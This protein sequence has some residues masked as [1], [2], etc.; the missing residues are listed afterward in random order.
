MSI[1]NVQAQ[2]AAFYGKD[3]PSPSQNVNPATPDN[4]RGN[5]EKTGP[6]DIGKTPAASPAR[7][8]E[9]S[10]SGGSIVDGV[11]N[12]V[13]DSFNDIKNDPLGFLASRTGPGYLYGLGKKMAHDLQGKDTD[14]P[15]L[16]ALGELPIA[17]I[18]PNVVRS[19]LS[20][21]NGNTKEAKE[22]GIDAGL[23]AAGVAA[24]PVLGKVAKGVGKGISSALKGLE[25]E[26]H[27]K[28]PQFVNGKPGYLAGP[29]T[30]EAKAVGNAYAV[31]STSKT[32]AARSEPSGQLSSKGEGVTQS[33]VAKAEKTLQI[34]SKNLLNRSSNP[35]MTMRED[36]IPSLQNEDSKPVM[37]LIDMQKLQGGKFSNPFN[38]RSNI[39]T[40]T[41]TES[42]QLA[43]LDFAEKNRIPVVD[44]NYIGRDAAR[45]KTI[46]ELA[47]ETR[48]Y[49]PLRKRIEGLESENFRM[50]KDQDS[51]VN[52][53]VKLSPDEKRKLGGDKLLDWSDF[54]KKFPKERPIILMG[55]A[56]GVCVKA[57]AADLLAK[58][59]TVLVSQDLV[60][61]L[62][63]KNELSGVTTGA[64]N[65]SW[66]YLLKNEHPGTLKIYAKE[67][68][69]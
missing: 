42:N 39:R 60:V 36:L 51:L 4:N 10:R 58:G 2:N 64:S 55:Q 56:E 34:N 35:N 62:A 12:F 53:T 63:K 43:M 15:V 66:G 24:G 23:E 46:G 44:V 31:P 49:G 59:R 41:E 37:L 11:K 40:N 3:A 45:K 54:D 27:I 67:E 38:P 9:S 17:G 5:V 14:H 26:G 50:L 7:Q 29:T 33:G 30:E 1:S 52:H 68:A 57:T 32:T 8:E 65:E 6:R 19:E 18:G 61:D 48:T 20:L 13:Q 47:E 21:L 25:N 69:T 28:L 22:A 16:K